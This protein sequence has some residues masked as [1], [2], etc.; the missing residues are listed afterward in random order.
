MVSLAPIIKV[1]FLVW[2]IYIRLLVIQPSPLKTPNSKT[3]FISTLP[4]TCPSLAPQR[5]RLE[6]LAL[7]ESVIT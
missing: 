3:S 2:I 4:I 7:E 6:R 1:Y 5:N